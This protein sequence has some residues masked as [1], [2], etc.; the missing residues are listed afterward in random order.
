MEEQYHQPE[1]CRDRIK[2]HGKK[3]SSFFGMAPVGFFLFFTSWG[4]VQLSCYKKGKRIWY[5][6]LGFA[7]VKFS[8]WSLVSLDINWAIWHTG[9]QFCPS[10]TD[11]Y[12]FIKILCALVKQLNFIKLHKREN[13]KVE[14]QRESSFSCIIYL[15]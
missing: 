13:S 2:W 10:I 6:K 11:A 3:W 15:S 5:I 14:S 7:W 9:N 1:G 4:M 8:V 12:C